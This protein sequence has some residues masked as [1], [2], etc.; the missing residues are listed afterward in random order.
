[1]TSGIQ[2][3][4]K[5]HNKI[6]NMLL[7]SIPAKAMSSRYTEK[8]RTVASQFAHVHNVRISHLKGRG[9]KH[10][11]DLKTFPRGAEPTKS[12]LKKALRTSEKAVAAMLAE[13]EEKG[14]VPSWQNSVTTYLGYF[15]SHEIAPSRFDHGLPAIR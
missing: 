9:K 15:I 14:K 10:L 1:M 7:D 3:A 5:V 6:N 13:C 4:W 11:G 2:E 12:E 8:T